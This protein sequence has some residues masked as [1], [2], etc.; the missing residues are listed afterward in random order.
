MKF[1]EVRNVT[2]DRIVIPAIRGLA[3]EPG[4]VKKVNPATVKHPAVSSRIGRGLTLVTSSQGEEPKAPIP[5]VTEPPKVVVILEPP[6]VVE[7]APEPP[8]PPPIVEPE[9]IPVV[10]VPEPPQAVA[11]ETESPKP[12]EPEA[13]PMPV[14]EPPVMETP[15][16]TAGNLQEAYLAAPGISE[17][18]VEAILTAFP[19]FAALSSATLSSIQEASGLSKTASRKL[20]DWASSQS[21]TA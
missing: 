19:T 6:K 4:E 10:A 12:V 2:R 20:R 14:S 16:E 8:P 3:F 17:E 18:N 5:T 15:M 13:E 7:V 21:V 1:V 11:V 9:I